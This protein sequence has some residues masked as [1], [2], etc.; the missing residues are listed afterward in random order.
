MTGV[1]IRERNG[2]ILIGFDV[3]TFIAYLRSR[4]DSKG[5]ANFVIKRRQHP[6]PAGH[7]LKIEPERK[8]IDNGST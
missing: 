2:N 4:Q 5:W 7:T 1:N 6:T 3:E 8:S